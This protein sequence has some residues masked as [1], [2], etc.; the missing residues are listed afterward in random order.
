MTRTNE[1]G[2]G[3]HVNL[4]VIDFDFF[5]PVPHNDVG[6]YLRFYDWGHSEAWSTALLSIMWQERAAAFLNADRKLPDV[7]VPD[8]FWDR[9]TFSDD[10]ELTYA[11]SNMH[12]VQ[13]PDTGLWYPS[14]IEQVW[15]FDAH[16]DSGYGNS[17]AETVTCEDW[18]AYFTVNGAETH[19]RYPTWHTDA[20]DV[21]PNPDIAPTSR[22]HDDG[23]ALDVEF[24]H[25]FVC[26]S[27]SWVPPWCD[28]DFGTF[29]AR[30]PAS[31]ATCL[32]ETAHEPRWWD[33]TLVAQFAA[34]RKAAFEMLREHAAKN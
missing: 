5:F 26:R 31:V 28:G 29:I 34:E 7:L 12:A 30:H 27:D 4:L 10:A 13:G 9:F 6:E 33:D 3:G 2:Y 32:D 11:N 8:D 18:L 23:A 21:E 25:T 22:Q 24:D 15:L 1:T 20:F 19:V 16:H 14:D 17:K